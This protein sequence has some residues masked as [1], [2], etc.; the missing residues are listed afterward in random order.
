MVKKREITNYKTKIIVYFKSSSVPVELKNH[1]KLLKIN[2]LTSK[3]LIKKGKSTILFVT[4]F[5][6]ELIQ[7]NY[8]LLNL[9]MRLYN[10]HY[11]IKDFAA[12]KYVID[13]DKTYNS[14]I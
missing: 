1:A 5:N 2:T 4:N 8:L 12:N 3:N 14:I 9:G 10:F 7:M 13:F 6:L 11:G